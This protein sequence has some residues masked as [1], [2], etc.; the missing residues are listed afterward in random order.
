MVI[1]SRRA[2]CVIRRLVYFASAIG[3]ALLVRSFSV[4]DG[5]EPDSIR[6][7]F[8]SNQDCQ[9]G[10]GM[11]LRGMM[12]PKPSTISVDLSSEWLSQSSP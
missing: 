12:F 10:S 5:R 9:A 6:R 3:T 4:R 2:V 1:G 8:W 11:T 7:R